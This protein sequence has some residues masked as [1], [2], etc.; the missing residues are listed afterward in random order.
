MPELD[1]HLTDEELLLLADGEL[2][3]QPARKAQQH[4]LSC[5]ECRARMSDLQDSIVTFVHLH[6]TM[7]DPHIPP[8]DAPRSLLKARLTELRSASDRSGWWYAWRW[9]YIGTALLVIGFSALVARYHPLTVQL[10]PGTH[11]FP[12]EPLPDPRLT[13]GAFRTV[14]LQDVCAPEKYEQ[15]RVTSVS[16]KTKVFQEYGISGAPMSDYEVDFL[17]IPQ[18]GGTDDIQNLWPEPYSSTAWNAH[19]KDQLE[20]RLL[21]LVC[22]QKIDLQT[23]QHDMATNWIA[24]YKRYFHTDMP[25]PGDSDAQDELSPQSVGAAP[26]CGVTC[27]SS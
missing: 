20:E 1:G 10:R 11:A 18:L 22:E 6:H 24:A 25:V 13:P 12:G 19:V 17:V 3:L 14:P 9:G 5:W 7:L 2:S 21:Q 4:L 16:L 15:S 27:S 23:A 26:K 8:A